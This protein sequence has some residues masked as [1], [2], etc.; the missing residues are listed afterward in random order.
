MPSSI[1]RRALQTCAL[2]FLAVTSAVA[3]LFPITP[4]DFSGNE[5]TVTFSGLPA[6]TPV[7]A[8]YLGQGVF[9]GFGLFAANEAD[10]ATNTWDVFLTNP[11]TVEFLDSVSRVGLDIRAGDGDVVELTAFDTNGALTGS[12]P[13]IVGSSYSFVGIESGLGISQ[14]WIQD[15]SFPGTFSIQ[16]L[17]F[18]LRPEGG[19]PE[20]GSVILAG[21]VAMFVVWRRARQP[22]RRKLS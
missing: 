4:G 10:T 17:R 8:N 6:G 16:D 18:D 21:T 15:Q 3:D 11:I 1:P 5:T 14:F 19:V 12:I 22:G 2:F 7:S 9:F 13:F 20:P